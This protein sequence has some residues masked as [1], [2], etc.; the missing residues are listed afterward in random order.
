[1]TAN[2]MT[3]EVVE[4]ICDIYH[5]CYMILAE[6]VREGF[7]EGYNI[8]W[9]FVKNQDLSRWRVAFQRSGYGANRFA[10]KF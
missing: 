7:M 8:S 1:M 6:I 2:A 9:D 5:Q 3:V 4:K 10:F